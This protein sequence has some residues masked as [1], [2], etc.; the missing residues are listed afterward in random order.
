MYI[1]YD[2]KGVLKELINDTAIRQFDSNANDL[3]IYWQGE[4]AVTSVWLTY[5]LKDENGIET[6]KIDK[7]TSDF[8]VKGEIPYDKKRNLTNFTYGEQYEFIHATI[9]DEILL[10]NGLVT[11]MIQMYQ[12]DVAKTMGLLVFNVENGV[13]IKTDITTSEWEYLKALIAQ[14]AESN[15]L[16][17]AGLTGEVG[18]VDLAN[19]LI[20]TN[21]FASATDLANYVLKQTNVTSKEQ[22]YGKTTGGTQEM[23]DVS[24]NADASTI[25]KRDINKNIEVG[26]A[27]TDYN[28]PNFK[29]VKD[30]LA[31]K[32]STL[33]A[34]N[35]IK[36]VDNVISLDVN[37][38]NNTQ[39]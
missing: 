30:L 21:L 39:Y 8:I 19:A 1:Y 37:N 38:A 25:V 23:Y 17:V 20:A 10:N 14:L 33:T 6:Q 16:S 18:A 15:V 7:L 22:V 35:G 32:Q 4:H 29:Q 5:I 26:N 3:Y 2:I 13:K 12:D 24:S 9:P 11:C 31:T 27:T 34:G 28:V 36:I